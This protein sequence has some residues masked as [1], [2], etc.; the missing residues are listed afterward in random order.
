MSNITAVLP[1]C[2]EEPEPGNCCTQFPIPLPPSMSVR[3]T[4][5]IQATFMQCDCL[6]DV[7][8]YICPCSGSLEI[9]GG[10]IAEGP[11]VF[12]GGACSYALTGYQTNGR[13][14]MFC[15]CACSWEDPPGSGQFYQYCA[16]YPEGCGSFV[17]PAHAS[18]AGGGFGANLQT[19]KWEALLG[20]FIT[21]PLGGNM[22]TQSGGLSCG[23]ENNYCIHGAAFGSRTYNPIIGEDTLGPMIFIGPDIRFC[24]DGLVDIRSAFGSYQPQ[25]PFA[26]VCANAYGATVITQFDPGQI[27]VS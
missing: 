6:L 4:G 16:D 19:G 14:Q 18:L 15:P 21:P 24:P 13:T 5:N 27:I 22:W 20:I 8:N 17:E 7:P 3:W 12:E 1:C 2:C 10:V 11:L 25:S 9:P 23:G 26:A